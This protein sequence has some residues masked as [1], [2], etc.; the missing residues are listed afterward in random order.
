MLNKV[1]ALF[2]INANKK[3]RCRAVIIKKQKKRHPKDLAG[4]ELSHPRWV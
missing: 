4:G 1:K 2:E 3:R